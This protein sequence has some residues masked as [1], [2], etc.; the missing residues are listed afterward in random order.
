MKKEN[1]II[2]YEQ[3]NSPPEEISARA[4][5]AL[6]IL[7]PEKDVINYLNLKSNEKNNPNIQ[8]KR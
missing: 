2:T 1:F 5:E 7:V 3:I 8:N 4:I 6:K